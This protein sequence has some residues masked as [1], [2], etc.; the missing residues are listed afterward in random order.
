MHYLLSI[1]GLLRAQL[2][3]ESV[4]SFL[5]QGVKQIPFWFWM[6][7]AAG[8]FLT[9]WGFFVRLVPR[10]GT[11]IGFEEL[12]DDKEARLDNSRVLTGLMVE[13]LT[14]KQLSEGE[15]SMDIMPGTNEPGFSGV[16]PALETEVST[17]Y[18]AA[19]HPVKIASLEFVPRDVITLFG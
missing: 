17:G 6:T 2:R 1:L 7:S 9:L 16:M 14:P 12:S 18:E 10:K 11:S 4:V 3:P 15:F 13:L 8:V 5:S 19:E